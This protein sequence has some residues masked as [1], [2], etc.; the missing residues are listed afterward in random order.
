[1]KIPKEEIGSTPELTQALD[2]LALDYTTSG[3]RLDPGRTQKKFKASPEALD[4]A[5]RLAR[6][7]ATNALPN[8]AF[9][10]TDEVR[11]AVADF[12]KPV[13]YAI[14]KGKVFIAS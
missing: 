7:V 5:V 1:M 13:M 9:S 6:R 2:K 4:S 3:E 10:S 14:T 11:A 12:L 8:E